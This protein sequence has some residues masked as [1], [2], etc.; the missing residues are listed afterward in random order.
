MGRLC[1][2]ASAG[3]APET[4]PSGSSSSSHTSVDVPRSERLRVANQP[5][6]RLFSIPPKA[7]PPIHNHGGRAFRLIFSPDTSRPRSY[8]RS[9][10][11]TNR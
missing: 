8:H 5:C 1:A 11:R 10:A 2:T 3:A 6:P 7:G 4:K 9:Q